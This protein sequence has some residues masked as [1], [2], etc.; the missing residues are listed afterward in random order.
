MQKKK[1]IFKYSYMVTNFKACVRYYLVLHQ[2]IVLQKLWKMFFMTY[3]NPFCS[4]VIQI[5]VIFSLLFH[6]SQV[7]KCRWK[8]NNFFLYLSGYSFTD[9]DDSQD[10]RGR[11][12]TIFI[13]HYHFHPL[14]I[15]QTFA[16][17][18][19]RWLS[20]IFNC[21]ACIYQTATQWVLPTYQIT[22]WLVDDVKLVFVYL[23]DDLILVFCYSNF[24]MGNRWTQTR[25]NYILVLYVVCM[26]YKWFTWIIRCNFWDN[27]KTPLYYIF[28][29]GQAIHHSKRNFSEVVL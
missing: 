2:M 18:H 13:P 8:W 9:T 7:Q 16:T 21:N 19:V 10:S 23:L 3:K 26:Y 29:L 20:R 22:V 5:F 6:T 27:S 11:D 17:L 24:D 15:I 1:K 28:K 12:W 14:T 25:I 4:R